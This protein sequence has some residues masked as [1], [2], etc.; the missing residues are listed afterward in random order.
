MRLENN[1]LTS[2]IGGGHLKDL[3]LLRILNISHNLFHT[4]PD[5]I[6]L[7]TNLEE[8]YVNNNHL[9]KMCDSI[10]QLNNLKILNLSN[11]Q[12]KALPENLG[13]LINIKLF[14]AAHNSKLKKLPK[15]VYKWKKI[16]ELILDYGHFE[17]P[18]NEV[19]QEGSQNI[20]QYI[21]NGEYICRYFSIYFLIVYFHCLI[22]VNFY[23]FNLLLTK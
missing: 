13:N 7:L 21:C 19:V 18:P 14:N 17:Y 10:C 11:N 22:N 23:F 9:K 6:H 1:A 8:L 12:L 3:H 15:S 5:D 16:K 20:V 2:L 4:L